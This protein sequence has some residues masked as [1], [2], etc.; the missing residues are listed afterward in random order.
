MTV[1]LHSLQ[2]G[3][4]KMGFCGIERNSWGLVFWGLN[5]VARLAERIT[6]HVDFLVKVKEGRELNGNISSWVVA[7]KRIV[8]N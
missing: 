1:S 7:L 5:G 3:R 6:L 8:G 2:A 4:K